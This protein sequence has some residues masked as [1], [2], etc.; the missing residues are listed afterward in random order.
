MRYLEGQIQS[1][2]QS[3]MRVQCEHHKAGALGKALRQKES[4][5]LEVRKHD[6]SKQRKQGRKSPPGAH[7]HGRR[8]Q[9]GQRLGMC[10]KVCWKCIENHFQDSCLY[11]S[12]RCNQNWILCICHIATQKAGIREKCMYLQDSTTCTCVHAHTYTH[13]HK[14]HGERCVLCF[15]L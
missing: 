13:T 5:G 6:F 10:F 15:Y 3:E 4:W 8:S 2:L 12:L 11:N 14:K 9:C 1:G 7:G